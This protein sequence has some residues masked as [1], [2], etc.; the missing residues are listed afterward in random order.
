MDRAEEDTFKKCVFFTPESWIMDTP[1]NLTSS[2]THIS[3]IRM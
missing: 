2:N 3:M 1:L